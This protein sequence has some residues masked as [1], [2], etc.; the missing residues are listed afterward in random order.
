[1]QR[2]ITQ[3]QRLPTK[4]FPRISFL[5]VIAALL[6]L[7]FLR[8]SGSLDKHALLTLKDVFRSCLFN[9]VTF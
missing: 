9:R 8:L 5:T 3:V 1:M 7:V 6:S 2:K 4:Y